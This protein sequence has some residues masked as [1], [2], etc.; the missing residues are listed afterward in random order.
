MPTIAA[1]SVFTPAQHVAML[2]LTGAVMFA[3]IALGRTGAE[4]GVRWFLAVAG[5]LIYFGS[6]LYFVASPVEMY[7][8]GPKAGQMKLEECLPIQACDVLAL[9]APLSLLLPTRW[10]RAVTYFGAFGLTTQAFL[11]PVID[12]GPETQKFWAFWLLHMSIVTCAVFDL[13][14]GRYRPSFGDWWRAVAF[15]AVYAVSMIVLNMSTGWFYGYLSE[16]IPKNAENSILKHLG[17]WPYRPMVMMGIVLVL[18]TLLWLPWPLV[19]WMKGGW[20]EGRR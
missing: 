15:W 13:T 19:R 17:P 3:T 1:S 18:F 16:K 20:D 5:V 6:G 9:L 11:T 8:S 2:M 12:T 4:R 10:L 7:Q 14:V